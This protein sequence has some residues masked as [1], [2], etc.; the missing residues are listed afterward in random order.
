MK[1]GG[2]VS[3]DMGKNIDAAPVFQ[4]IIPTY[5]RNSTIL[6]LMYVQEHAELVL[7][8]E[9]FVGYVQ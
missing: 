2:N 3:Q 7:L 5:E 9:N 8:A 6:H 4:C 1:Y